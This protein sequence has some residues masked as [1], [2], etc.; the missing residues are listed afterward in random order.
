MCRY[1]RTAASLVEILVVIAILAI[2]IGL[3]LPAVQKVREA[4][5]RMEST[6]NVKQL[7]LAIHHYESAHGRLPINLNAGQGGVVG[8]VMPYLER[9]ELDLFVKGLVSPA[10]PSLADVPA[11]ELQARLSS[12][13]T[14][15]QVFHKHNSPRTLADIEDGLSNTLFVA[16]GQAQCDTTI[17]VWSGGDGP[18]VP[19]YTEA[20][21]G[22][23]AF[24]PNQPREFPNHTG[25]YPPF[26]FQVRPV[27][28][29]RWH[30]NLN[31]LPVIPNGCNNH[32]AQTP[33]SSG[34]IVGLGDGS[35]RTLAPSISSPTYWG[36]ITPNGG[37]VAGDD[38]Q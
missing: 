36:S 9:S 13:P 17:R 14:N 35:V 38:W 4:A 31:P 11:E 12:Y 25:E 5:V 37:E 33:H 29:R 3:L 20:I 21:F 2:L 7:G 34:M 18:L 27:V 23:I 26:T 30:M 6:N 28:V 10:D 15:Y 24:G 8:Q 1:P 22:G 16:E 19:F 32:L